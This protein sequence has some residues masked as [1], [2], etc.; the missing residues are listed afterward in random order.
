MSGFG[1]K[2][3]L[4]ERHDWM[5][6]SFWSRLRVIRAEQLRRL[7][8]IHSVDTFGTFQRF[9]LGCLFWWQNW[10]RCENADGSKPPDPGIRWVSETSWQST[11]AIVCH[12]SSK[13]LHKGLLPSL[14]SLHWMGRW[15]HRTFWLR[16]QQNRTTILRTRKLKQ[17]RQQWRS[18]MILHRE[19]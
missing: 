17:Q 7:P 15:R 9:S 18:W 8:E 12:W 5:T 3:C 16:T 10:G 13:L 19:P 4:V 2:L 6:R 14:I 1:M 11:R